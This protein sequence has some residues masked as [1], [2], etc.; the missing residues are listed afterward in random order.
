MYGSELPPHELTSAELVGAFER[1][2]RVIAEVLQRQNPGTRIVLFLDE[3]ER[4]LP[5][6]DSP[7][8]VGWDQFWGLLRAIAQ[9]WGF[10][11]LVIASVDARINRMDRLNGVDNPVYKFFAHTVFLPPLAEQED[12]DMI[13]GIGNQMGVQ[14]EKSASK[15]FIVPAVDILPS[16]E[17]SAAW[18]S[19]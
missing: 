18:P 14:W 10:L 6:E 16:H 11:S 19:R 5:W 1:D 9:R 13:V 17:R 15:L 7:G 12:Y 3:A 4:T 8:F 2:L